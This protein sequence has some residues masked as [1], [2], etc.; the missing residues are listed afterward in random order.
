MKVLH[1]C[2]NPP[3]TNPDHLFLGTHADNMRD[4]VSKK[5]SKAPPH[6]PGE[7]NGSAR[8]TSG[9]VKAIRNDGATHRAIAGKFGVCKSTV[10][11]IKTGRGWTCVL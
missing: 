7:L 6:R 3:C 4:C 1:R 10:T 5:R 8:L 2:D 9:Q 11:R